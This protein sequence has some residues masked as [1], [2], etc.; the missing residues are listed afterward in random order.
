MTGICEYLGGFCYVADVSTCAAASSLAKS[1][2]AWRPPQRGGVS[3][4]GVPLRA[5]DAL[6]NGDLPRFGSD[7]IEQKQVQHPAQLLRTKPASTQVHLT[8][9]VTVAQRC[10]ACVGRGVYIGAVALQR[11]E[12]DMQSAPRIS[13]VYFAGCFVFGGSAPT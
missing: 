12:I 5:L 3:S 10:Q 6:Q 1:A 4:E 13:G 8:V 7:V 2:S 9:D 11:C